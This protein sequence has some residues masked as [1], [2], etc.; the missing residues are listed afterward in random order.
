MCK[1]YLPFSASPPLSLSGTPPL[2]RLFFA[3]EVNRLLSLLDASPSD[4]SSVSNSAFSSVTERAEELARFG[5]FKESSAKLRHFW[6]DLGFVCLLVT[7]YC[8]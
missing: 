2:D 4:V 3:D 1:Y 5:V 8:H 6:S 7:F